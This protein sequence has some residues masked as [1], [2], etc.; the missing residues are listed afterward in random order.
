M[1]ARPVV[2][3]TLTRGSR[4][5]PRHIAARRRVRI[6]PA[7]QITSLEDSL[8]GLR[9]GLPSYLRACDP[10]DEYPQGLVVTAGASVA[11]ERSRT[12]R[13]RD[14][15]SSRTIG[16]AVGCGH[17]REAHDGKVRRGLLMAAAVAVLRCCTT[18]WLISGPVASGRWS[19]QTQL[20][21]TPA[22]TR[23]LVAYVGERRRERPS[24][25]LRRPL[26]PPGSAHDEF[27]H[28]NG[29]LITAGRAVAERARCNW[30]SRRRSVLPASL[31]VVETTPESAAPRC[32]VCPP[33]PARAP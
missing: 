27:A 32:D 4:W 2:T 16:T 10:G 20:V 24:R 31:D 30:C 17:L 1:D 14:T 9:L 13:A 6:I 11:P 21:R 7:G 18:R 3:T 23:R 12:Q 8:C 19:S 5:A 26:G 15:S 25:E 29:G 22:S 33:P 28:R